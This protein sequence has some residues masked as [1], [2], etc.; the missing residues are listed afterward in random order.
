MVY[1]WF[2]CLKCE[3]GGQNIQL[4]EHAFISIEYLLLLY[5]NSSQ[6]VF[7]A[8]IGLSCVSD[9]SIFVIVSKCLSILELDAISMFMYCVLGWLNTKTL[10]I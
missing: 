3:L 7:N 5:F 2:L 6:P 4:Y 1:G 9:S 10:S 8:C